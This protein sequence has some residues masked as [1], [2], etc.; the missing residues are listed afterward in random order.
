MKKQLLLVLLVI[1][2]YA[3]SQEWPVRKQVMAKHQNNI[4]FQKVPAFNF[5]GDKQMVNNGIYQ[6][7]K[8]NTSFSEKILQHKP[9]A[10]EL[11]IPVDKN[12]SITCELIRFSLGNIKF[13]ENK[14]EM[15]S[16]LKIP[17]TYRGIISGEN[18]KNTVMLTVNDDYISLIVTSNDGV[19]QV[20]NADENDKTIYRLYNSK[21]INFP[22]VPFDCGT[23]PDN[24]SSNPNGI[25]LNGI[26]L[27]PDSVQNKCVNV[28]VDCFDSLYYWRGSNKQATIDYVY[29]LFNSVTTGYVNEQVNIYVIAV[30]VWT[31]TDPYRGDTRENALADL[32]AQYQDAFWG[33]ICVGLDYSSGTGRSGIAGVAGGRVKANPP[34]NCNAYT[35]AEHEFCYCDL[36][37]TQ[38]AVNPQNF[39]TGPNTT[40]SAVYL[41]MH[42]M[43]HLLGAH[44]TK[45]CGWKLT[46]NPDTYGMLDNC[47]PFNEGSCAVGPPV[48]ATG[49]T[50]MSY[51]VG[52]N[53]NN[54]A[55]FNNGFG[56]LPGNALRN[57]VDQTPCIPN[58]LFCFYGYS[59]MP[60]NP[61][62]G[63]H[64]L[65]APGDQNIL[66]RPA[67]KI[68]Y[69][70]KPV[71]LT[72]SP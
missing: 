32:A 34:N 26:V 69:V 49:S 43:G 28:F 65:I 62:L 2:Q 1:S 57:F 25:A 7:L 15:I 61:D 48:G 5:L 55:N 16:G 8:L 38:I 70:E 10:I 72:A 12:Q 21:K 4:V 18:N 41:T 33:N 54:F 14:T 39:P 67:N 44:H 37:Y 59:G 9:E 27:R 68:N 52:G 53:G 46:S 11:I 31:T 66:F 56:L 36:N 51:C 30:N 29:E 23:K 64:S 50:I 22:S 63:Y 47:G 6:L 3:F 17:V 40:G 20:T 13:T 24:H 58:C 60:S 35:V 45:W 71:V 42:E 19:L